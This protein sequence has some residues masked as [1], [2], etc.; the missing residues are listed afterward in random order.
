MLLTFLYRYENLWFVPFL[1]TFLC[2]IGIFRKMGLRVLPDALP[3]LGD[4][5]L[6]RVLFP[7]QRAFWRPFLTCLV[8]VG[9]AFYLNPYTGSSVVTARIFLIVATFIYQLFLLRLYHRLCKVFGRH[10]PFALLTWLLPPLGLGIL[11]YSNKA[12]VVAIPHYE[13][14]ESRFTVIRFLKRCSFVLISAVEVAAVVAIVGLITIRTYPPRFVTESLIE[15]VVNQTKDISG[16]GEV[17]TR[18]QAMSDGGA[19]LASLPTSREKFFP[20]HDDDQSVCVMAYFIGSDLEEKMGLASVNITQMIDATTKGPHLTFA[21]QAG[22][23]PRWFTQGIADASYGR[24]TISNGKLEKVQDLPDDT[25]MSEPEPLADFIAWAKETY[26]ADRYILVMWDHG[27]GLSSGCGYDQQN[28]RDADIPMISVSEMADAID[29]AGVTFDAI[30]FDACLMQ[31]IEVAAALEPYADYLIASEETESG[32]G[33]PYTS[34]FAKLA[35][36]P[37]VPTEDFAHELIASYDP[38]NSVVNDGEPATEATLSL[39]DLPL[40][41][42]CYQRME[43]FFGSAHEAVKADSASFA[44][45]SLAGTKAYTFQGDEQVDLVDFLSRLYQLDAEDKIVT[46]AEVQELIDTVRACVVMRN[47][48]SAEGVNGI[49]LTLPV[50]SVSAY[51]YDHQ[52]LDTLSLKTQRKFYDDF[53][54]IIAA[55]KMKDIEQKSKEDDTDLLTLIEEI[56]TP[57]YTEEDW[58]VEGFE[59]YETQEALVDIPLT[60][61]EDGY[62]IE[63]PEKTWGI[64]SDCRTIAY[65]RANDGT[66]RYLGYD[67]T[68]AVDEDGNPLVSMDGTWVHVAGRLACY[69]STGSRETKDGVVFTGKVKARLNDEDIVTLQVE[70]DPVPADGSGTET[71]AGRVT[72]YTRD[73][74]DELWGFLEDLDLDTD[75]ILS[76][77]TEELSAGDK[78]EF[79]F[80]YYDDAGKLVKTEPYGTAMRVTAEEHIVVTDEMLDPCNVVFGG[81]LTDAYQR[82]M[83]TEKIEATL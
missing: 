5:S 47:A 83:T 76:R 8:L 28:K 65:Q 73:T 52:Q 49:A 9:A 62:R 54:S 1:L 45:I 60:E 40:A 34:A 24:Y 35:E 20:T 19:S 43:G 16:T 31:D 6:T 51:R 56:V 18:E 7:K 3:I 13:R 33:W 69:E 50:Q 63:L 39:V 10:L 77:G 68:G 82:T 72:G 58:Y 67:D 12:Q 44:H 42:A 59:D 81:M 53:F 64:I 55:Q 80:D 15:D 78:V 27:G 71:P 70:W 36:D 25:C 23:S 75:G 2:Y 29:R 11:G 66:L 37:T 26:P 17:V 46:E 30:G 74:E 32:I 41:K 79:L 4:L 14:K 61:V 48:N 22:G 38:Y 21:L 57:D